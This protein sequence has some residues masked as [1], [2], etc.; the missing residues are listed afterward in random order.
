MNCSNNQLTSLDAAGCSSLQTLECGYNRIR[1][2]NV[3]DCLLLEYLRCGRNQLL[4]LDLSNNTQLKLVGEASYNTLISEIEFISTIDLTSY[5]FDLSKVSNLV[6]ARIE[7]NTLIGLDDQI[8]YKYNTGYQGNNSNIKNISVTVINTFFDRN[9]LPT[10]V[11]VDKNRFHDIDGDGIKECLDDYTRIYKWINNELVDT[12][13]TILPDLDKYD[14]V[15]PIHLNNDGILD[16]YDID[17]GVSEV[18]IV[19]KLYLSQNG[20]YGLT[21]QELPLDFRSVADINNDGLKDFYTTMTPIDGYEG[22]YSIY[23]QN[24]DGSFSATNV[25]LIF[26]EKPDSTLLQQW[27]RPCYSGA[28]VS[29]GLPNLSEE[30]FVGGGGPTNTVQLE[31]IDVNKDGYNDLISS[32]TILY[33]MG[34]G[35]FVAANQPGEFVVKDISGD[36]ISDFIYNDINSGRVYTRIYQGNGEWKEQTLISDIELSKIFCYDFDK[37]E[38]TDILLTFD[39]NR[40]FQYSF[41]VL[42]ENDGTGNFIV[43][44][45]AYTTKWIFS[46]CIDIDNDGGFEIIATNEDEKGLYLFDN[47]LMTRIE[48]PNEMLIAGTGNRD[49][50]P[51]CLDVDNDG[52]YELLSTYFPSF[53]INELPGYKDISANQPPSKMNAPTILFSDLSGKLKVSWER[54]IDKESSSIDLSYALRIGSQPGNDDIYFS[55]ANSDGSRRSF[56]SGN[57]GSN[58]ETILDVSQWKGGDYY[59][60]VQAIDPMGQ[61]S[62]WSDE[63][64]YHHDWEKND[65]S[66]SSNYVEPTDSLILTISPRLDLYDYQWDIEGGSVV[67]TSE[68]G[69]RYYVLFDSAGEKKIVL[70]KT[71]KITGEKSSISKVVISK[72]CK[73]TSDRSSSIFSSGL[74]DID[75]NGSRDKYGADGLY[76]NDGHGTFAKLPSIFNSNLEISE[77]FSIVDYDMD[78]DWDIIANTN[79]GNLLQNNS[80]GAFEGKDIDTF[81]DGAFFDFDN[82]GYMDRFTSVD[83]ILFNSGDNSTYGALE[84]EGYGGRRYVVD[85]NNDGLYDI[86]HKPEYEPMVF[87]INKGDR[88]FYRQELNLEKIGGDFILSGVADMNNDGY[89]DLIINQNSS[90][91]SIALGSADYT[92]DKIYSY[93][94][95][96]DC[97]YSGVFDV[98]NDGFLDIIKEEYGDEDYGYIIYLKENMDYELERYKSLPDD[99]ATIWDIDCDGVP[100]FDYFLMK[101]NSKNEIPEAPQ[102]IR[103]TQKEESILLEW[104][105]AKDQET[106]VNKMGYN[107]SIKKRG[108]SGA[109]AY[110]LSSQIGMGSNCTFSQ[111][112]G[113]N[114]DIVVGFGQVPYCTYATQKEIPIRRFEAGEEYEVQIQSVDLWGALS[115]LSQVY[116]FRVES[117]LYIEGAS[118][119]GVNHAVELACKGTVQDLSGAVIELDGGTVVSQSQNVLKVS[120]DTPGTKTV[121]INVNGTTAQKTVVVRE[122]PDMS[123]V[124][125]VSGYVGVEYELILPQAYIEALTSDREIISSDNQMLVKSQTDK[126]VVK[127]VFS[128]PG[129]QWIELHVAHKLFGD[130]SYKA[131]IELQGEIPVPVISLVKVDAA[132]GKNMI[133]WNAVELPDYIDKVNVY[134]EGPVYDQFDYV[135]STRP[136]DGFYVDVSSNPQVS[137]NR[138]LLKY[139]TK[140][141]NESDGSEPHTGIHLML[142]RGIGTAV[143]LMWNQYEGGRVETFTILR[144]RTK[145][146]LTA[147]A[148]VSGSVNSY[149]D[150]TVNEGDYFYSLSYDNVL[151]EAQ[152]AP[153][154]FRT[155]E[156]SLGMSNIVSTQDAYNFVL[157][158]HLNVIALE[159]ELSLTPEQPKLHFNAEFLPVNVDVRNVQWQIVE[160][161]DLA[162]INQN[163]LLSSK[164]KENGTIVVRAMTKDGSNLYA[165]VS[166]IKEGFILPPESLSVISVDDA[167]KITPEHSSLQLS[168]VVYPNGA[169]QDVVWSIVEGETLASITQ[170]GLLTAEGI[171]NGTIV[172]RAESMGFPDIYDLFTVEKE[173]FEVYIDILSEG[174][175]TEMT[176]EYSSLQL[177]VVVYPNGVSQD[178]VWSI[179][180]GETLASITQEGL[181][182]AEGMENGTIVVRAE[183]MED[184]DVY[185]LFT[186]EKK[187]FIVYPE[188][189]SIQSENGIEELTPK[190]PTLQLIATVYPLN[191]SQSVEWSILAGN[192]LAVLS[193]SGLLTSTGFDNGVIQVIAISTTDYSVYDDLII[194][195]RFFSGIDDSEVSDVSCWVESNLYVTGFPIDKETYFYI[196]GPD[197]VMLHVEKHKSENLVCIDIQ[198]LSKGVYLLAVEYSGTR[199]ILRFIKS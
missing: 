97:R 154:Y 28:I 199:K 101:S 60:S 81:L 6:N 52:Y 171:E 57:M 53:A 4:G 175:V 129:N 195:K 95:P 136:T 35:R 115:P 126:Q 157:T 118:E 161:A 139:Q 197:G 114:S 40:D 151:T 158:E 17:L 19:T 8:T 54:G 163:G 109:N 121:R 198:N 42:C 96:E 83:E 27:S 181:L 69:S 68:D 41:L 120:W 80:Q 11:T 169:P 174:G 104:D 21:P 32:S 106:P 130:L 156:T 168:A 110:I 55:D 88:S 186:V 2:I 141:G 66:L 100:D 50:S 3:R 135:G 194:E 12:K 22:R 67:R 76:V 33:N 10:T 188:K 189:V 15:Q 7:D 45:N 153:M 134:K 152:K 59:I 18:D 155:E 62:S 149:T 16:F 90:V 159:E 63:V 48:E 82:D 43:H 24:N 144:G 125:P 78:G 73:F 65:F 162:E 180:E 25:E 145:E 166:V 70:T 98:N 51:L 30:M 177:L 146:D 128:T 85:V 102:N 46:D 36:D 111:Y 64:I 133:L 179:V 167:T 99:N 105:A 176:P 93:L 20:E 148:R 132:T 91:V 138:Y 47:I 14:D 49:I 143:N 94:L 164:G 178:V 183:S 87:L 150:M 131:T 127:V 31:G 165:E 190:N 77:L 108:A 191:A 123:F 140:E 103:V 1:N 187:G 86:V 29:N 124:F 26:D 37:D 160:G 56:S 117:N 79:K 112:A 185:D 184:P 71:S 182:T 119:T 38:D 58:L 74:F 192:D 113:G 72:N 147:I 13:E 170:E 34:E 122:Q 89:I 61:G 196:M 142:N 44:E 172:V 92:F 116:T 137:S 75:G 193:D 39:Y 84:I 5:D 9:S 173:D 23:Y 107:I